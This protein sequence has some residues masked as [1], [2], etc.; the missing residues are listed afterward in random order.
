MKR[1]RPSAANTCFGI[2]TNPRPR[3]R[4]YGDDEMANWLYLLGSACFALGT[5]LNML[6]AGK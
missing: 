4:R 2:L 6:G 1:A 3:A 5:I